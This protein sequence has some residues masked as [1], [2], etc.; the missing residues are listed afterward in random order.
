MNESS[1]LGCSVGTATLG[2]VR[3]PPFHAIHK[4]PLRSSNRR[5]VL[6]TPPTVGSIF[7]SPSSCVILIGARFDITT[8]RRASGKSGPLS[9]PLANAEIALSE[10][11]IRGWR[12]ELGR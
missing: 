8:R 11:L 3:C 4:P 10:V 12:Q 7:S 1:K 2:G 5:K 9:L 6:P